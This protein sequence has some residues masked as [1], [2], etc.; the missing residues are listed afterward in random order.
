MY[1][2]AIVVLS[3][4]MCAIGVL[5]NTMALKEKRSKVGQ[6]SI[7]GHQSIDAILCLSQSL[8]SG[9]P[10][11]SVAREHPKYGFSGRLRLLCPHNDKMHVKIVNGETNPNSQ[12]SLN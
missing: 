9:L 3:K 2:V 1:I 8:I 4:N 11:P 10:H 6:L 5:I 7:E 12:N